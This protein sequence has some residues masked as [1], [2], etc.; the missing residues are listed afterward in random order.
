MANSSNCQSACVTLTH[1]GD[2]DPPRWTQSAEQA[3]IAWELL[4][5]PLGMCLAVAE[6]SADASRP[7]ISVYFSRACITATHPE[8]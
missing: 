3:R 6:A 7:I 4:V 5:R 2:C 8:T 1:L